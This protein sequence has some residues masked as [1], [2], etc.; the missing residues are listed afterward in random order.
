MHLDHVAA[1]RCLQQLDHLLPRRGRIR[2]IFEGQ[3]VGVVGQ[4]LHRGATQRPH[5]FQHHGDVG[6]LGGGEAVE[7]PVEAV[8]QRGFT[9]WLPDVRHGLDHRL[10][11]SRRVVGLLEGAGRQRVVDGREH[12][13]VGIEDAIGARGRVLPGGVTQ[14]AFHIVGSQ[15]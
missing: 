12:G 14:D 9:E 10:G 8:G 3:R 1:G 15:R 13:L 7:V 2:C 5:V 6:V 11:R 4:Q